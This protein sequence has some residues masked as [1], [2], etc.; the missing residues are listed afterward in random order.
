MASAREIAEFLELQCELDVEIAS[1]S[2]IESASPA[3]VCF[4]ADEA[5]LAA[6]LS[7]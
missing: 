4:A 6:A 2:G 7:S 1:V 5:T 3:S